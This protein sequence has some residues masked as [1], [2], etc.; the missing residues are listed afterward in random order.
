MT[1]LLGLDLAGR[2][3]LVAGGG[4]VASRRA[5][6]LASEGAV[7]TVVSPVV[8][9]DLADAWAAGAVTWVDREVRE[10]DVDG[11]W[12]VHAATG[13]P[14][15][16]AALCGWATERRIWSV[17]A[18]AVD[19]GTAR[20]PATA[21]HSGLAVGVV[22]TGTA[23]PA[24]ARAVRDALVSVLELEPLDLRAHRRT[25]HPGRVVLVGGGPGA[26]DLLTL[27]G[28]R[29][30]SEADVVVADRLG[31]TSLLD[32]L[33]ETVEVIDV[34]K[35]PGH[36]AVTQEQINHIIVEQATLGRNVVRLKGGDAYLFGRG[37]EEV[38]A[39]RTHGIPVE[40][41]PG[42]SSALAVPAA[43][44]IPL[45]HRGV[46]AGAHVTHGH[47]TLDDAAVA[48]VVDGTATLV[49]LMGIALL[50]RH[51]SHLLE[52]G[53]DPATPVAIVENGTLPTQ[54]T[55]RAPLGGIVDAA[56]A[57]A[58]QA[59]AVVVVGGVAATGLLETG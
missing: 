30:L 57:A 52:A 58:V 28:R 41:V 34:G 1:S 27:R 54:R 49:V 35:V 51:V 32:D 59:P 19:Q 44:D 45:T 23:D 7:V 40:V 4:P 16:D 53:A 13:D 29:A 9:E 10:A 46:V 22:S 6:A 15:T 5:T 42:V 8:C 33:P 38:L 55:T 24:R 56:A 39:C 26:P 14:R 17:N 20:T 31:P 36:H 21:R 43:A 47:G 37:G 11:V 48:G 18:G 12:L 25:D 2:P 50:E 3:V